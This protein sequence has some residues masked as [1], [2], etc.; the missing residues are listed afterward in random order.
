[1]PV[2]AEQLTKRFYLEKAV[3]EWKEVPLLAG[4]LGKR[5]HLEEAVE[6]RPEGS[7]AA[8]Q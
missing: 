1:M 4:R 3:V 8:D 2:V 7:R 6:S 5:L